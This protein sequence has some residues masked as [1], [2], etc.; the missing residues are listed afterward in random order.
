MEKKSI[1]Y[2][3]TVLNSTEQNNKFP[4]PPLVIDDNYDYVC[5]T[6]EEIIYSCGWK[7]IKIN[8]L[9]ENAI[10]EYISKYKSAYFVSPHQIVTGVPGDTKWLTDIPDIYEMFG[11]EPHLESMIPTCDENG[12]YV[13]KPHPQFCGG[14]YQGAEYLVTIG[15]PVSNQI[16]TIRRCMEG[17]K[18]ILESLPAEL[19]VI[20]TGSTDGTVEVTLEYGA[21]VVEF[22]WCDNMSAT[23]NTGIYHAK[24]LWYLSIDDDEWF[25]NVDDIIEFFKSGKYKEYEFAAYIQRN[26]TTA[27]GKC[28]DD[29]YTTR[30]AK[31]TKELHFEGRIH[32]AY[33]GITDKNRYF[34]PAIANHQGFQRISQE[35]T[36]QKV[37]RNLSLLYYDMYEYP[38][39]IRY[40]F[41]TANEFNTMGDYRSA[42]AYWYRGLSINQIMKDEYYD[43]LL[44]SN[45]I[46]SLYYLKEDNLIS[47]VQDCMKKYRYTPQELAL[48]HFALFDVACQKGMEKSFILKEMNGYLESREQFLQDINRYQ[49]EAVLPIDACQNTTYFQTYVIDLLC[50]YI[51]ESQWEQ[52]FQLIEQVNLSE[53]SEQS[54]VWYVKWMI[55]CKENTLQ[56]AMLQKFRNFLK[57]LDEEMIIAMSQGIYHGGIARECLSFWGKTDEG[58]VTV[59]LHFLLA[60]L[61]EKVWLGCD[62]GK[63]SEDEYLTAFLDYIHFMHAYTVRYY[64]TELLK[65]SPLLVPAHVRAAW[66]IQDAVEYLEK[67]QLSLCIEEL[68]QGLATYPN[69]QK[70]I[71]MILNI[72]KSA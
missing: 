6:S 2:T 12:N 21:R 56:S 5:F 62:Q 59:S 58:D 41:Q 68:K 48:F 26:Y 7:I 32:D 27:D 40:I 33:I 66:H 38:L 16:S 8:T 15:V 72:I 63:L 39:D 22:P 65:D 52:A 17:I 69:Y 14:L 20:D 54:K 43:K 28:Y 71:S 67:G 24:G 46:I 70:G 30:M 13:V 31:I 45:L 53:A 49:A 11:E 61:S 42:A 19:L 23:R 34:I 18:P 50:L 1:I 37:K 4:Y 3:Y 55:L 29:Y 25:E 57:C 10:H 9:T 60:L 36:L 64:H 51:R 44:S 47:F 35:K